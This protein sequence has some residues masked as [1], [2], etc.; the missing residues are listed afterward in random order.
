MKTY[1]VRDLFTLKFLG[2]VEAYTWR[3]AL[4][5]ALLRYG[6]NATVDTNPV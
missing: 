5:L 1:R 6:V 3:E 2:H 4:D